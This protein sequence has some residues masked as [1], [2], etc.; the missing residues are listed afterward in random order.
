[1]GRVGRRF[2]L[3]LMQDGSHRPY[4]GADQNILYRQ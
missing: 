3:E 2:H 4:H 1:L